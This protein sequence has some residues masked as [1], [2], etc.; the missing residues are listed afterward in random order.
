MI[1][2]GALALYG[3]WQAGGP[4]LP[5]STSM[6]NP[7]FQYTLGGITSLVLG[8]LVFR[9]YKPI[10]KGMMECPSCGQMLQKGPRHCPACTQDL[11]KY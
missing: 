9:S 6:I 7:I 10:P 3:A 5:A 2:F 11:L 8:V 1:L 4:H